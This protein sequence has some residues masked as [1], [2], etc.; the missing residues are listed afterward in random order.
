MKIEINGESLSKVQKEL[1]N[2]YN[3]IESELNILVQVS[4]RIQKND[5]DT[6]NKSTDLIKK[7]LTNLEIKITKG[8]LV[9][10]DNISKVIS[11]FEE[12][13]VSTT[14][15]LKIGLQENNKN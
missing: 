2:L 15:S 12:L 7:Q 6:L 3:D 8:K 14:K 10:P 4:E 9:T 11:I 13:E 1:E 5:T